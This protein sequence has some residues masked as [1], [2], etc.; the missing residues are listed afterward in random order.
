MRR[1]EGSCHCGRVRFEA[2]LDPDDAVECDCSICAKKGVII[3]R[4]TEAQF[5]LLTPLDRLSLYQFNKRIAKH[6]FC[7][8]CGIQTFARPRTAPDLWAVNLR[9]LHDLDPAAL[10]PRQVKGSSLD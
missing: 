9:C 10:K 6:Y 8:I 4:V 5:R 3:G 2:E 1:F 7:P